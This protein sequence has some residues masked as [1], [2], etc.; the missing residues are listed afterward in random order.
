MNRH[1]LNSI[2]ENYISDLQYALRE[3]ILKR[4]IGLFP[5]DAVKAF[6]LLLPIVNEGIEDDKL[7]KITLSL[8]AIHAAL[9]VHDRIESAQATSAEQQLTVLAGD[10]FSGIHY[11]ILAEIGEFAFIRELSQ[12]IAHINE[13]KTALHHERHKTGPILLE[14]L[15]VIESGCIAAFYKS[16]GFESYL[17]LAETVLTIGRL[18]KMGK[19]N[20]QQAF[21][22]DG[23][24]IQQA[25]DLLLPKL[26]QELEQMDSLHPILRELIQELVNS[27]K[28]LS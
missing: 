8:G 23:P 9:D 18:D 20:E 12:T 24:I 3:S 16:Y 26:Q 1:E 7:K 19:S 14:R 4:E 13:Q 25:S 15:K 21:V 28:S 2:V 5:V 11:R 22:I 27:M 6:F 10:H 17:E